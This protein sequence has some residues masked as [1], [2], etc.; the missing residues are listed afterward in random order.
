MSIA[1]KI[2]EILAGIANASASKDYT[3]RVLDTHLHNVLEAQWSLSD[4]TSSLDAIN[5]AVAAA[6][7]YHQRY[8]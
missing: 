8:Q 1:G 4:T 6:F 3:K 7:F 2:N 5:R